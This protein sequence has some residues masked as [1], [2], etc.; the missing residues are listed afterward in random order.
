M[1]TCIIPL[2]D[3]IMKVNKFIESIFRAKFQELIA[4]VNT[5]QFITLGDF[6]ITILKYFTTNIVVIDCSCEQRLRED[7]TLTLNR[8]IRCCT[9]NM[10]SATYT[11]SIY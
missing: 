3:Y 7:I 6:V 1:H 9:R 2:Y 4:Q 10:N 11:G 5:L 8:V